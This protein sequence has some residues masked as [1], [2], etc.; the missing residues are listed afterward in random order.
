MR[1]LI[2][3]YTIGNAPDPAPTEVLESLPRRTITKKDLGPENQA[4]CSICLHEVHLGDEV[5]DLPCHHW[6]HDVCVKTWLTKHDTCPHRRQGTTPRDEFA[7]N[8]R[9]RE[10]DEAPQHAQMWGQ[11]RMEGSG[12]QEDP[13]VVPEAPQAPR[14]TNAPGLSRHASGASSRSSRSSGGSSNERLF[15]RVRSALD[16]GGNGQGQ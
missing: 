13:W 16:G 14:H 4:E 3:Q 10:Y 6:F 5:T 12:T 8:A 9:V 7:C 11:Q 15:N 2:E 1:Q